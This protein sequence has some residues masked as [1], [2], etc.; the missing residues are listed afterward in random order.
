MKTQEEIKPLDNSY[1]NQIVDLILPIQQLEFNVSI[2]VNDQPDLLD[3][4]AYY[5]QPGGNFW[6]AFSQ[7]ELVGTIA[8]IAIGHQA[9]AIR[10]M[11]VKK[12]FRGKEKSIAQHLLN[13]LIAYCEAKNIT[14]IYLGTIAQMNAAQR[15]YERNGFQQM[16]AA[17]LP[18]YFPRM[19]V[20]NLFYHLNLK[21]QV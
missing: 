21:K 13:Q 20:D 15:F 18:P 16:E 5:Q 8:L 4:E 11:F 9:G 10:K 12:E 7:N 19:Q 6:G 1:S 14:D 17:H 3:I 2:T